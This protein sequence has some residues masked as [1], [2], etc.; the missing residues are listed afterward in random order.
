MESEV[1]SKLAL[2]ALAAIAWIALLLQLWLSVKL[3]RANAQSVAHGVS[4][5]LAYFTVLT[6]LFIALSAALPLVAGN[7]RVGRYFARSTVF[8]CAITSIVVVGA[9]YHLLLR[10]VWSPQGLQLL[11]DTLLH[12]VVPLSA[13]GYWLIFP[14]RSRLPMRAPLV[15][16]AFPVSYMA[17]IL[18]RGELSGF[19]PYYFIDVAKIGYRHALLNAGAMLVAFLAAGVLVSIVPALRHRTRA[20]QDSEER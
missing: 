8:G 5:F 18:V 6:N 14:P 12:Y 7:K 9:G 20:P 11:A 10:N 17:Y 1:V 16:C 3:A 19:Y 4:L 2:A 15:W 13:L